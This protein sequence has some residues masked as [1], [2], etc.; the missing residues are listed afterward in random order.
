MTSKHLEMDQSPRDIVR[1]KNEKNAHNT[2]IY[3]VISHYLLIYNTEMYIS[4]D[5]QF[6]TKSS[7]L[8]IFKK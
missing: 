8:H 7:L 3:I 5:F 6:Y 4:V 2:T 1:R